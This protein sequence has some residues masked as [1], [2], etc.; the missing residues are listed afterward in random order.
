[1]N[2]K[3]YSGIGQRFAVALCL[4]GLPILAM[5]QA[6][7]HAEDVAHALHHQTFTP[8]ATRSIAQ[9]P[10][11]RIKLVRADGKTVRLADE[12]DD[13]RAV[14]LDFVYTTC[15]S[16]CPLSSQTLEA[17]QDRLGADRDH[18][19]L[20]SISIDPEQDTPERLVEYARRFE[21]GPKWQF[22]TG[23]VDASLAV[24]R[25][26]AAYRGDKMSHPPVTLVR[27][28]PG[29]PWIRFDGF[30]TVAQILDELRQPVA[31]R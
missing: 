13:G 22:Y 10:M 7:A 2:A 26:F 1:M 9:Y 15:T 6:N 5:A 20:V 19:H 30:V 24:Q 21:A 8:G 25:A 16:V 12:L 4:A 17:L 29:K 23:T 3:A 14:V 28:A 11:P 27:A 31:A 18:V